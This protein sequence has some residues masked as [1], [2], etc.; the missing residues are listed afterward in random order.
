M[1]NIVDKSQCCGCGACAQKCPKQCITMCGDEEGFL[2]PHVEEN[3]CI[4]CGLCEKVCPV[5]NQYEEK[6]PLQVYAAKNPN[7][8]IRLKSSSGG[9]F[10]MFAEYI[11]NQGGFVFGAAFDEYWQVHHICIDKIEDIELLRGSKYVQ[12]RIENTYKDAERLLKKGVLV[13]FSGTPCQISGLKHYLGKN[14][15]NLLTIDIVCHGVPSP[16]VWGKY[17]EYVLN[18]KYKLNDIK[19]ISF[20]DKSTGWCGYSF[21]ISGKNCK[22]VYEKA[23]KNLYMQAFLKN[24]SLRPSCYNCS[25]RLGKC[26][27]DITLGD[28]WGIWNYNSQFDDKKGVSMVL[29]HTPKALNMYQKLN[30]D[31]IDASYNMAIEGNPSLIN[32][33]QYPKN[34]VQ[35][36]NCL[37]ENDFI[38]VQRFIQRMNPTI[39]QRIIN[40]IQR[41]VK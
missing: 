37:Y 8:E 10:T 17:Q 18:N 4:N 1:I 27:S 14:Y 29:I 34:R 12:S 15:E 5:V 13:L 36:W 32:E 41:I 33:T 23:S 21:N 7:E 9:L 40:K 35:F 19:Q 31:M 30:I 2:Y 22:I 38:V 24:L 28:F 11:I 3:L 25:A 6:K 16:L 26:H 39:I 20:R